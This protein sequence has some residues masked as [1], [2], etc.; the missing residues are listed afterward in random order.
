VRRFDVGSG[1]PTTIHEVAKLMARKAEAP[2]PKVSGKY[3]DG[4]VRAASCTITDLQ[5]A[6][7]YQPKVSLDA[8]LASLLAF[9]ADPKP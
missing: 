1:A 2:E 4:D 5:A 7:G 9:V 6:L 3:R 8:G